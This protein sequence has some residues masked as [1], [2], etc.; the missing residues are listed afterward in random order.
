MTEHQKK[1]FKKLKDEREKHQFLSELFEQQQA[2]G[3]Y[4]HWEA[5]Y[6]RKCRKK[7]VA[8]PLV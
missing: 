5:E 6:R 7:G 3:A 2:L 8:W 4:Q 1:S